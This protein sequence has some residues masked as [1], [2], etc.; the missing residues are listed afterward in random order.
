MRMTI[1]RRISQKKSINLSVDA[2]LIEDSKA[3]G[4]NISQ[5]LEEALRQKRIGAWK[6]E[7]AEA[8]RL[9]NEDIDKNGIWSD[10]ARAW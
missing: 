10:G 3:A 5:V 9:L 4:L 8:I 2:E 1:Q 7:N 6:K